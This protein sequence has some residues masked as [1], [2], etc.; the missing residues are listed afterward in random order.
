MFRYAANVLRI[1]CKL[2][3]SAHN[4]ASNLVKF[5]KLTGVTILRS[6]TRWVFQTDKTAKIVRDVAVILNRVVSGAFCAEAFCYQEGFIVG[7]PTMMNRKFK[8]GL[9]KWSQRP[10]EEKARKWQAGRNITHQ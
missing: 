8:F 2:S 4:A 1:E 5:N 9:S 7:W 10:T 3:F 6:R